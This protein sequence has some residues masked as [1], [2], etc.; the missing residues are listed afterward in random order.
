MQRFYTVL[1]FCSVLFAAAVGNADQNVT[2]DK[3]TPRKCCIDLFSS[4]IALKFEVMF[5]TGKQDFKPVEALKQTALYYA[6]VENNARQVQK[7]LELDADVNS[8]N[9]DS[10]TPLDITEGESVEAA[11]EFLDE[12]Q[13]KKQAAEGVQKEQER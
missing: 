8:K 10:D 6:A 1:I 4:E 13:K 5:R 7:C 11:I 12:R 3:L 2:S 9:D